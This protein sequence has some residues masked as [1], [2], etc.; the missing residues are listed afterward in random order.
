MTSAGQGPLDRLAL[1]ASAEAFLD[2]M[3]AEQL[4]VL[5]PVLEMFVRSDEDIEIHGD[6]QRLRDA[7]Y[8]RLLVVVHGGQVM[9]TEVTIKRRARAGRTDGSP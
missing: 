2:R 8:S 5:L 7:G 1:K 3:S 4:S 9:D 6:L